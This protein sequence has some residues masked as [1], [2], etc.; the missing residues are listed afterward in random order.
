[1]HNDK[2]KLKVIRA[3]NLAPGDVHERCTDCEIHHEAVN[4][5]KNGEGFILLKGK[6]RGRGRRRKSA[7]SRRYDRP[8]QLRLP[9]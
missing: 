9:R 2:L 7:F 5:E 3:G 8:V 4:A 6:K 1:M